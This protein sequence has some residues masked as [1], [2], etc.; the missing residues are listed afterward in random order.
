MSGVQRIQVAAYA[1]R[2]WTVNGASLSPAGFRYLLTAAQP[3]MGLDLWLLDTAAA[4]A[5]MLH[6]SQ[7]VGAF[8]ANTVAVDG[9]PLPA[10]SSGSGTDADVVLTI[11]VIGGQAYTLAIWTAATTGTVLTYSG[12][13]SG[14]ITGSG[15]G[16]TRRTASLTPASSGTLTITVKGNLAALSS[17]LR[18]FEG[19]DDSVAWL[20]GHGTPCRVRV[21]DP[22]RA[23]QFLLSGQGLSDYSTTL[24]E[25]GVPG[26]I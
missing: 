10:F 1:P 26:V 20:P 11:P 6:P 3:Q 8:T 7:T 21:D 14:S 18:L 25:V 16:I 19:A 4:R 15:A 12:A 23:L 17:G 5:N 13:A 24:R 22:T 9:W 2:T